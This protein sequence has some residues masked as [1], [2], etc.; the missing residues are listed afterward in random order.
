MVSFI[1]QKT[2]VM[3]NFI[4]CIIALVFSLNSGFAQLPKNH[5]L[6]QLIVEKDSLLF[7]I[8]FNQC[9]MSQFENLMSSDLEFYHDQGGIQKSKEE[10][11]ANFKAG[12]CGRA[13]FKSR[14]ELVPGSIKVFPMYNNGELYGLLQQGVHKF[15]ETFGEQAEKPGS[16]AKFTHLW[17]LE[18]TAWRIQRILSYDHQPITQ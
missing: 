18:G 10:N 13:N 6:H 11:I 12:I 7:N 4:V 17:I 9:D 16:I 3:K 15:Y 14:R 5:E 2:T 1:N 8:G